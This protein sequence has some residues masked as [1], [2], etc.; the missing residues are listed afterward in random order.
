M[1]TDL[2]LKIDRSI[3]VSLLDERLIRKMMIAA[4]RL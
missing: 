1:A 2:Q 3:E 4:P